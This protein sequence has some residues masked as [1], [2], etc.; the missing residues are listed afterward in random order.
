MAQA[1]D[2][3]ARRRVPIVVLPSALVA[4]MPLAR[5]VAV[6]LA[7]LGAPLFFVMAGL[8]AGAGRWAVAAVAAAWLV[9]LYV[10]K[11]DVE[12]WA[13]LIPGGLVGRT[14]RAFGPA[15]ARAG[16]ACLLVERLAF[17]ALVAVVAGHYVSSV[18]GVERVVD[19]ATSVPG[20]ERVRPYASHLQGND[21]AAFIGAVC[22]AVI[23]LRVRLGKLF[24]LA[25]IARWTW[26]AIAIVGVMVVW[27]AVSVGLLEPSRIAA[28]ATPPIVPHT[29]PLALAMEIAFALA[30]ALPAVGGGEVVSRLAHEFSAP[31]VGSLR[32]TSRAVMA[33]VGVCLVA[34]T[35]GY[36]ALVPPGE[37]AAGSPLVVLA[38]H[39]AGPGIL[40]GTLA[41]ALAAAAL[42]LLVPASHLAMADAEQ[43][44]RRLAAAGAL[45][46]AIVVPH[47]R[48]RTLTRGI[49]LVAAAVVL[50]AIAG[51]GRV[52]WLAGAYALALALSIALRAFVLARLRRVVPGP[53]PYT[54]PGELTIGPRHVPIGLALL[55]TGLIAL[56]GWRLASGDGPW[57]ASAAFVGVVALLLAR[58]ARER[59]ADDGEAELSYE[60][61]GTESIALREA[62][63]QPGN[64]LVAVRHPQALEHVAAALQS[65]AGR[66]V[67]VVTIRLVGVDTDGTGDDAAPLPAERTLF[68]HVVALVERY[69]RPVRLLIVPAANVAE[70]L[71]TAIARLRSSAV[72]VGE[73]ATL[74]AGTQARLLGDAWERTEKPDDLDVRL[75]IYHRSG[76]TDTYQLGAHLPSLTPA[77]LD[78]IHRV[79]RI[80]THALGPHVHHHDVVRAALTHMEQQLNGPTRDEVLAR[81][82]ETARP[83]EELAAVVRARDFTRL[84]DM[85]RNRPADDV[86]EV[87]TALGLED[88]V[89]TFRVLPRRDAAAVFEYLTRETQETLLKAM[90][91]EDVGALL[92]EMAPDDRTMFLEELPAA[93]TR[94]MLTL[95]TPDERAVAVKL[96]GYPEGSIGRLMTPNYVAVREHWTIRE[97]LDYVRSHGQDSETLNVLYVVDEHHALV[98]DIRIREILLTDP[99]H[100]VR[101]LL[102]RRFVAL[103]ATDDQETAV[104]AFRQHDRVALPVTDT[105]GMLIGIVTIDDIIDVAEATVTRDIQRIGGSEA[106]DEP[107]M[108]I[109][110]ST[111]IR[112]RAGW[113]T[114]LFFGEMLTA[115]AMG[116]FEAEISKA[117]VLALFVPLII[118]SG[119][120]SGSQASTLVI[121][122]LALGEVGISDWWRVMRREVLVGLALGTILGAI[123]FLRISVWSGFSDIY[124]PHWM[125]LGITVSVALVGVV[126]WGTVVGSLLPLI[127]RRLGFDPATSSAPF[128]A[129]LID[130]TGLVIYFTVAMVVLRGSLL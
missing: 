41:V 20:V 48:L 9:G 13:L 21:L 115:T 45:P 11:V 98:D 14:E 91:Q 80:A 29:P 70:G 59:A 68:S 64:I 73:S 15:A 90:A 54:A 114:A 125:L 129:T 69:A 16:A 96:L 103:K 74:S 32:R 55:G 71:A 34:L 63:A 128:V 3:F 24:D 126:L 61:L 88:Q 17:T 50:I 101:D 40:R 84:R 25:T 86:A 4:F 49:D 12:S 130:V 78:L 81:I 113:L 46:S 102:D 109:A 111:M 43:L 60:V 105:A 127:L 106:L 56:A 124:G 22:V 35:L 58:Q 110:F 51:A 79:W 100:H 72:Y 95:L 93:A 85:V 8:S 36:E 97:V 92:N 107:Y 83:A 39:L 94:Q 53:R 76:R 89:V 99:D 57:L 117:V 1:P 6:A 23:W 28:A 2:F 119:G 37:Q 19:V 27:T 5:A 42:L 26:I 38:G 33:I 77:D 104:A 31:R 122:A 47:R 120:N 75:V 67:V 62:S 116:S 65:S 7:E 66:D 82:R 87:L 108:R 30:L 121:R 123:G 52:S 112:K 118:S 18:V 44:L 10:R